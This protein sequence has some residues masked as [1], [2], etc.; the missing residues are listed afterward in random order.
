[1]QSGAYGNIEYVIPEN[2]ELLY[3]VVLGMSDVYVS[4]IWDNT[5]RTDVQMRYMVSVG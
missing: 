1:M 3:L 2:T 5:E 4:H